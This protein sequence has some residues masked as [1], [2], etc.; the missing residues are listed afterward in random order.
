[1]ARDRAKGVGHNS[2]QIPHNG[3]LTEAVWRKAEVNM[4]RRERNRLIRLG[5]ITPIHRMPPQMLVKD[6]NG[7]WCPEIKTS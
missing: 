7:R 2:V 3:E 4:L 1:M 6:E 5:R